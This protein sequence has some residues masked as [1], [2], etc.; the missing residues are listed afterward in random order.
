MKN[1]FLVLLLFLFI[2]S[3]D[4]SD[5]S[6]DIETPNE[7]PNT[8]SPNTESPNTGNT[9]ILVIGTKSEL[10]AFA[11]KNITDFN[12]SIKIELNS[13]KYRSNGNEL[14][15]SLAPLNKLSIINGDLIISRN[16]GLQEHGGLTDLTGLE[17]LKVINGILEISNNIY[18][19][20]CE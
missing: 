2:V 15:K 14:I 20:S 16:N 1:I 10:E 7:K 19:N 17:N 5:D 9:N 6:N 13:K 11:N 18:L 8:E 12:G 4:H 3:C